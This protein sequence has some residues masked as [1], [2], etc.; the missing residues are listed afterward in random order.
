MK[1]LLWKRWCH[2]R[3]YDVIRLVMS[4]KVTH[5]YMTHFGAQKKC[6]YVS[7]LCCHS[8]VSSVM[9]NF[10][11]AASGYFSERID[12]QVPGFSSQPDES[13]S[14]NQSFGIQHSDLWYN[15]QSTV[16]L[17]PQMLD[18]EIFTMTTRETRTGL[19]PPTDRQTYKEWTLL[20]GC[21]Q[22]TLPRIHHL[23]L[24]P[25]TEVLVKVVNQRGP[26]L[27]TQRKTDGTMGPLYCL[28][29]K[30]TLFHPEACMYHTFWGSLIPSKLL[31]HW[32]ERIIITHT[33][34]CCC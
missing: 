3:H 34:I 19:K 27:F 12:S 14:L 17:T 25:L 11:S 20:W 6:C 29:T 28:R 26:L 33:D 15:Q 21:S 10:S 4:L 24:D 1:F 22:L 7:M 18:L 2:N 32:Q 16:C 31:H 5:K 9:E 13:E 30:C 23:I 8:G